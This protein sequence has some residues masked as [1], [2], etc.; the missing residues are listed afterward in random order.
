MERTPSRRAAVS[1]AKERSEE[2][3]HRDAFDVAAT[4]GPVALRIATR[5]SVRGW[6]PS[7]PLLSE[8][9]LF[10]RSFACFTYLAAPSIPRDVLAVTYRSARE[11]TLINAN[12][13]EAREALPAAIHRSR[14]GEC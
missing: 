5:F 7:V 10:P 9:F 14:F 8:G 3:R 6:S 1:Q 12:E 4:E 2:F 11:S 13:D